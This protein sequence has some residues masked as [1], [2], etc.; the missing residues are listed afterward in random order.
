MCEKNYYGQECEI[1][2][3]NEF[4]GHKIYVSVNGLVNYFYNRFEYYY[5]DENDLVLCDDSDSNVKTYISSSEIKLITNI[6]DNDIYCDVIGI[7]HES[8]KYE[9]CIGEKKPTPIR[10]NHCNKEIEFNEYWLN[11]P[12]GKLRLGEECASELYSD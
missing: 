11:G 2:K 1:T 8:D 5:D 9:I 10:C 7:Y 12:L 4:V 3:L 6:N